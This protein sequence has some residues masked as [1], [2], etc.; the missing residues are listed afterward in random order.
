VSNE[1]GLLLCW[2]LFLSSPELLPNKITD[3]ED[4]YKNSKELRLI[5]T[6]LRLIEKK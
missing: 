3:D 6:L 1:Q 5:E 4:K 2:Y